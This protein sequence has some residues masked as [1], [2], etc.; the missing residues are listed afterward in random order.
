MNGEE[1][2][3]YER[4]AVIQRGGFPDDIGDQNKR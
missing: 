1:K 3:R 4:L 2:V